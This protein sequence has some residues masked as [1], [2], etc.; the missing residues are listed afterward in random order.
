MN[1]NFYSIFDENP[2]RKE[3]SPRWDATF[4][5][6]TSGTIYTV[7]SCLIERTPGLYELVRQSII[8]SFG[9][10]DNPALFALYRKIRL[11]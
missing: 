1:L 11:L 6:V 8:N 7:C 2:L 4:R 9:F 3:K 5:G 10:L